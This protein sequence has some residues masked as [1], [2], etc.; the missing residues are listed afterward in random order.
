MRIGKERKSPRKTDVPKFYAYNEC[1]H[2]VRGIKD[3]NYPCLAVKIFSSFGELTILRIV[4][5]I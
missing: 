5:Y 4:I 2:S 3:R 1:K